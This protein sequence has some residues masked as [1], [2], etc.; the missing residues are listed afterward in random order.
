[1]GAQREQTGRVIANK[2]RAVKRGDTDMCDTYK[3]DEEI[4]TLVNAF[5]ACS[6]HPSEFKHYQHLAVALWYVS[7]LPYTEASEKMRSG[8]RRLAASYGKSG[9]HETITVFWLKVVRSFVAG[10]ERADSLAILANQLIEN[11][12]DKNLILDYY[13][14]E[15]L[16]SAA[17]K[18]EW[19]EPDLKPMDF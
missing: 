14:T 7:H 8:I 13:S 18:G 17:A 15:S 11:Y 10:A 9:Y 4:R 2:A 5:E 12:F 16:A 19:I 1:M 3:N 6:F